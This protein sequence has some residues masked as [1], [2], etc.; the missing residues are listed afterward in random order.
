[1]QRLVHDEAQVTAPPSESGFIVVASVSRRGFLSGLGGVALT[2][3]L[4]SCSSPLTAGLAGTDA[5]AGKLTYWN[6]FGGGDGANMLLME[7]AF[8][9]AHRGV[10]VEATTLAWGNPYYTKLSLATAG[11]K[12]PDVAIA[13]LTRLPLLARAGIVSDVMKAGV[14]AAGI[15]AE[16]F[17][18]AAWKKATVDGTTYAIPLDTHPFV[19]F[20]NVDMAK[21]AGLLGADGKLKP[22]HGKDEFIAAMQAMK[23]ATG[24]WG[25]VITI[26]ADTATSWRWFATLYY[27]LGGQVVGNNGTALLLDD[28]KAAA[29]L[30][31]MGQLTGKLGLMPGSVDQA[32]TSSLF[33]SGKAGFLLDG[34][35]QIP[36]YETAGTHFSVV[37]IPAVMSDQPASYADSHALVIPHNPNRS[38]ADTRNAVQFIRSLLDHSVT[39]AKGGH[40]PAWLPVQRSK[41]FTSLSPQANYVQAAYNARYD[42]DAWYTGA[43][44]DFQILMGSAVGGVQSGGS[45]PGSAVKSMRSG[46]KRYTQTPPPVK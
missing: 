39:W 33:A 24:Q 13:H 5:N 9:A 11:G 3:A 27:Q 41:A 32:G 17:T 19:M 30:E 2:G 1:M 4:A 45:N 10:P 22:I 46:L 42:P 34:V 21:K 18:P 6:L 36:T 28:D 40:V 31:F 23:K 29:A 7:D 38:A 16:S 37:P 8:R 44:S 14:G 12:P 26:N 15:T 25:G 43:G 35:W 20:Y